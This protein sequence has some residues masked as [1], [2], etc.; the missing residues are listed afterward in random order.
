MSKALP[1]PFEAD[2]GQQVTLKSVGFYD[3]IYESETHRL[4]R[5]INGT[6]FLFRRNVYN[7]ILEA[8]WDSSGS[9]T[10]ER[11]LRDVD[12]TFYPTKDVV[13]SV[14][15][16]Q[17][18]GQ[19]SITGIENVESLGEEGIIVELKGLDYGDDTAVIKLTN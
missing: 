18:N 12:G 1:T 10:V 5:H 7:N 2:V 4:Y 15:N 9:I 19:D 6:L 16:Q 17:R 3:L 11:M 14:I 8:F 13:E